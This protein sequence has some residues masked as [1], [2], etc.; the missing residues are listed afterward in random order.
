QS[1]VGNEYRFGS[2]AQA[3]KL[4]FRTARRDRGRASGTD[5][6]PQHGDRKIGIGQVATN[7]ALDIRGTDRL[8]PLKVV[9][10]EGQVSRVQPIQ[11]EVRRHALNGLKLFDRINRK[12]T[13]RLLDFLLPY[14]TF[15]AIVNAADYSI[16]HQLR[17]FFVTSP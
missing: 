4:R 10:A 6:G 5:L 7:N 12:Y 15:T 3:M 2:V 14:L 9:P 8:Y 16:R 17:Y 1:A 13:L 11:T